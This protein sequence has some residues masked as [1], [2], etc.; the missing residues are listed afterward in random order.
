MQLERIGKLR[1]VLDLAGSPAI[2][3]FKNCCNYRLFVK[4]K[5]TGLHSLVDN[6]ADLSIIPASA[7]DKTYNPFKQYAENGTTLSTFDFK[8]N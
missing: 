7:K 1:P 6:G 5:T 4:G 3:N 2:E 8:K